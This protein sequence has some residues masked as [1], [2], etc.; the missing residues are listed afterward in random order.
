MTT[1]LRLPALRERSFS[2]NLNTS[3][4]TAD[5]GYNTPGTS[6]ITGLAW[7]D[8]NSN[9][10]QDTGE[11][12]ISGV[13]V[14]LYSDT[15]G[16]STFDPATD[17]LVATTTTDS[18][19]YY[20]FQVSQTGTYFVSIDDTQSSIVSK[21]LT[22]TDDWPIAPGDQKTVSVSQLNATYQN[23]NFGF[24]SAAASDLAM[25]KVSSAGA[26]NVAPGD[27]ITYTI[28]ITNNSA[29][30]TQTGITVYDLL[31]TYTTYVNNST[32]ATGPT[33]GITATLSDDFESNTYTGGSGTNGISW[34]GGWVEIG[35]D[36]FYYSGTVQIRTDGT[37]VV[38]IRGNNDGISRATNLSP[39][40]LPRSHFS[41]RRVGFSTYRQGTLTASVWN[42]TTWNTLG[43][44]TATA[45]DATYQTASY[46]INPAYL[47]ANSQ[48]R[49]LS[50]GA[51]FSNGRYFNIDNVQISAN[52]GETKSNQVGATFPLSNGVPPSLVTAADGFS[53]PP[54]NSIT[55]TYSVT[56]NGSLP[57]GV[58][59]ILNEATVSSDQSAPTKA[60]VSNP[61]TYTADLQVTKAI[62]SLDS[63]CHADGTCHAVFLITLKN[64]GT[65]T[66]TAA[67]VTDALPSN[68]AYSS[69]TATAGTAT[70]NSG[71]RT[72]TWTIA[73]SIAAGNSVT[74]TLDTIVQQT[75]TTIQ[76]CANLASST[77][78]DSNSNN[79]TG[80][81]SISPTHVVLSGFR[82]YESKGSMVVEW[83]TSS[84][85]GTAGFY[86]FRKD[87]ST[88]GYQRINRRLLPALL[89]S[90]QGGTYS[91]I[92][93]G[94]TPGQSY[95]TYILMEVEAGGAK[96]IHGPFIVGAGNATNNLGLLS[97]VN[98]ELLLNPPKVSTDTIVR[99]FASDGRPTV[100]VS[101]DP[102]K[103]TVNSGQDLFSGYT[104]KAKE[105]A[106]LR[107]SQPAKK[108]LFVA[109]ALSSPSIRSASGSVKISISA[110][111]LY[112]LSSSTMA[113][114]FGMPE[115]SIR[116]LIK[117][118]GFQLA[119][120]GQKAAY[121]PAAGNAGILFY[122]QGMDNDIYTN[123]NIYWLSIGA[124]LKMVNTGGQ[125]PASVSGDNTFTET[126][127]AEQ[128]NMI[129]P[130]L[131]NDPESDYWFWD[132]IVGG[133]PDLGTK[134]FTIQASGVANV[135]STDTLSINLQGFTDT[136]HHISVKLNG[137]YIGGQRMVG[138]GPENNHP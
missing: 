27:T 64:V 17:T 127:H 112:S 90:P 35:D 37:R 58:T 20:S 55:V 117:I 110:D 121:M 6:A 70:Y 105:S 19:G 16:N 69:S 113:T 88:G 26:G 32:S 92:D 125:N 60:S 38:S 78:A 101:N 81:V 134:T 84:E 138:H 99:S 4:L 83:T 22:T 48:I 13:T 39:M 73:S 133:D 97:G 61:V 103:T 130:V 129:V 87:A 98:P 31:P 131:S 11:T 21:T 94:A 102:Y 15:N 79:N 30:T 132:Y 68:L 8:T 57:S 136:K 128:D 40:V 23:N 76:N 46:T 47:N 77:P 137:T 116:Q 80:C 122:G 25:T 67:Q 28:T 54:S 109:R 119:N 2:S 7:N 107:A 120:K 45:G 66:V 72:V 93:R 41:Y 36:T 10:S 50:G 123:E 9:G 34:T 53:L 96:N 71:N 56:V 52:T 3:D 111:G 49:F 33:P 91:L 89:T 75:E 100:S 135:S 115:Q 82:A 1:S 108:A 65:T 12:G 44:I 63:P 85:V 18:G 86:L 106:I 74:L 95:T 62:Q 24:A 14:Q 114:L 59:Q 126:L 118:N 5:F 51:N 43:T 124:G 104:R 42:G 29:T